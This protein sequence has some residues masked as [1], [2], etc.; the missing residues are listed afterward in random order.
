MFGK[1]KKIKHPLQPH[2]STVTM[3]CSPVLR[4]FIFNK[5]PTSAGGPEVAY[6]EEP[7]RIFR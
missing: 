1:E 3:S 2:F 6:S 5:L 4:D 7:P